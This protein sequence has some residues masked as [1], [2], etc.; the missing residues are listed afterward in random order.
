MCIIKKSHRPHDNRQRQQFSQRG[1]GLARSRTTPQTTTTEDQSI[2]QFVT[3][4]PDQSINQLFPE[5]TTQRSPR[6]IQ[7]T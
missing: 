2:N 5:I 4:Q 3:E 1:P 7:E 6:V